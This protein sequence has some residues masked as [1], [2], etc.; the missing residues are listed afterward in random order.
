MQSSENP[1]DFSNHEISK[2][3]QALDVMSSPLNHSTGMH[4]NTEG[5]IRE[6]NMTGEE[7]M[8]EYN[9]VLDHFKGTS[10]HHASNLSKIVLSIKHKTGLIRIDLDKLQAPSLP[11]KGASSKHKSRRELRDQFS[12]PLERKLAAY[13]K[14]AIARQSQG[15]SGS[16]QLA[17]PN[18]RDVSGINKDKSRALGFENVITLFNQREQEFDQLMEIIEDNENDMFKFIDQ[19]DNFMAQVTDHFAVLVNNNVL[20]PNDDSKD[21]TLDNPNQSFFSIKGPSNPRPQ[22]DMEDSQDEHS[23]TKRLH[24]LQRT[25]ELLLNELRKSNEKYLNTRLEI[26]KLKS[27]VDSLKDG[28]QQSR[29]ETFDAKLA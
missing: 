21:M 15:R 24:E 23:T 6:P 14:T 9:D 13:Q 4:E 8:G 18:G 1:L 5:G 20:P 22:E 25:N 3:Y 16:K 11:P 26:K 28:L 10:E 2:D 12:S 7:L 19:T 17:S 27:E 29:K